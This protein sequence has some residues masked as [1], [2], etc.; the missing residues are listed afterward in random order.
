MNF[1]KNI[2]YILEM[3]E[4]ENKK[5]FTMND[6][7]SFKLDFKKENSKNE[8]EKEEYNENSKQINNSI[9][10]N[11]YYKNTNHS[12]FTF[13]ENN[14]HHIINK[15]NNNNNNLN[16]NHKSIKKQ[17]IKLEEKNYIPHNFN[18][19]NYFNNNNSIDSISHSFNMN[20]ILNI[21]NNITNNFNNTNINFIQNNNIQNINFYNNI[22]NFQ[23]TNNYFQSSF[24]NNLNNFFYSHNNYNTNNNNF[25]F[26]NQIYKNQNFQ[27]NSFQIN[28]NIQSLNPNLFFFQ[29]TQNL[30]YLNIQNL[31][32]KDEES[33]EEENY[34]QPNQ[35]KQKPIPTIENFETLEELLESLK[36]GK[37]IGNYIKSRNNTGTMINLLKKLPSNKLTELLNMIQ[38]KLKDIMISNNKLSQKLFELCNTEQRLFILNSIKDNFIE[39]ALNKWGSFSLQSLIKIVSLP[40]EQEIIKKCIEGKVY[41]LAMDKQANFVLQKLILLLNEKGMSSITEEIFQIFNHLIYNSNGIGLL[42]NLIL[43]NK[44]SETRKKFVNKV[45]ENLPNIINNPNGHTLILQI[46]EKW[47]FETCKNM[48]LKIFEDISKYAILKFSSIVVLK[49][50]LVSDIKNIKNVSKILFTSDNLNQI[51]KN[52]NGKD[53]IKK[54]LMKLPKKNKIEAF[55]N[56]KKYFKND[57][58]DFIMEIINM[59]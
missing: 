58:P 6:L 4:F 7:C 52:D 56:I 22:N 47:D 30:N 11:K 19:I 8:I 29:N 15:Y 35:K 33:E 13:E 53:I 32:N 51:I 39:I 28:Q 20:P 23:N 31:N 14:L 34:N 57:I 9:L 1:C 37:Q 43:T 42:K 16:N 44:S 49:C 45:I 26:Q 54:I 17:K 5:N 24:N 10:N 46:M 27:N 55:E 12:R 40:E 59:N 48:I 21:N 50:V 41:E 36:G 2:N 25:T 18:N 38:H 3:D